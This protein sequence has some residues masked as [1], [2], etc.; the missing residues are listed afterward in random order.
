MDRQPVADA[1]Y[2]LCHV[3]RGVGVVP[4]TQEEHP[5]IEFVDTAR[6]TVEPMRHEQGMVSGDLR[7]LRPDG[8][9]CMW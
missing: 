9:E 5:S 4:D 1:R 2:V 3:N 7:G 6:R 8:R